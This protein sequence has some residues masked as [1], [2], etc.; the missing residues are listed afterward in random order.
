MTTDPKIP[1]LAESVSLEKLIRQ[2]FDASFDMGAAGS[3]LKKS[4]LAAKAR[5]ETTEAALMAAFG[6]QQ[7]ALASRSE[8]IPDGASLL[9]KL[10]RMH[11]NELSDDDLLADPMCGPPEEPA[12]QPGAAASGDVER[13]GQWAFDAI[14]RLLVEAQ[15]EEEEAEAKGDFSWASLATVRREMASKCLVAI[16][17]ARRVNDAAASQKEKVR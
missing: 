17:E 15:N 3:P 4:F 2:H 8:R 14:Q 10:A 6:S 16:V 12:T 5:V 13:P 11:G 9:R 7:L 1:A